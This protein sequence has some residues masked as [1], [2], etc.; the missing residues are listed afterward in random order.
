MVRKSEYGKFILSAGE[1]GEYVV[2][3]EAWR[4]RVIEGVQTTERKDSKLGSELHQKWADV[5]GE[6]FF[7]TKGVRI[8]TTLIIIAIVIFLFARI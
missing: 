6:A 8:I 3:P 1:I 5:Y 7:F 4:L 2:C